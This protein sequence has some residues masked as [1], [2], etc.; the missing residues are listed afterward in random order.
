[1]DS[2]RLRG[3]KG[4]S[5]ERGFAGLWMRRVAKVFGFLT[6][7][8]GDT[9]THPPPLMEESFVASDFGSRRRTRVAREEGSAVLDAVI[10]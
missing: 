10:E 7:D 1:M 4:F 3:G 8:E 5:R 9:G 2:E 6:R